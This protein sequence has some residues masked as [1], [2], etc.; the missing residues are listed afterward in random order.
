MQSKMPALKS[1]KYQSVTN[2]Q[3]NILSNIRELLRTRDR[4]TRFAT[5]VMISLSATT[6]FAGDPSVEA[7]KASGAAAGGAALG[8][9]TFMAVGS[10]GL[11]IAGTAITVGAAPF[12]IAGTVLGLA[13]YGVPS[14]L[15]LRH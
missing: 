14:L 11:T 4:V 7:I 8:G 6:S 13:G 1:Q 2:S 15:G 9:A 10:G 12:I 5:V 3:E